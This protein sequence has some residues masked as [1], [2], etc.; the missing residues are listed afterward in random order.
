MR[1]EPV[2]GQ[3]HQK[4]ELQDDNRQVLDQVNPQVW[5]QDI[6]PAIF[7]EE[8]VMEVPVVKWAVVW[9]NLEDRLR[10]QDWEIIKVE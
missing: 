2:R 3:V 1:P 8:V 7:K 9:V 6:R 10:L 5:E 4:L